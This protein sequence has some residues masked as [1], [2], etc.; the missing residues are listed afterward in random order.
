M[1]DLLECAFAVSVL[2]SGFLSTV[3][4]EGGFVA[5]MS[6]FV[7]ASTLVSSRSR[8]SCPRLDESGE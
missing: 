3:L 1:V 6:M 8:F 5:S 4:E 2:F 7:I